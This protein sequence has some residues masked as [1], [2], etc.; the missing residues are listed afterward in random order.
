MFTLI[1]RNYHLSNSP[2]NRVVPQ[3]ERSS[4][5][6]F[7]SFSGPSAMF[8]CGVGLGAFFWM[9]LAAANFLVDATLHRLLPS[10]SA[11]SH[12]PRFDLCCLLV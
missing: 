11:S 8:D 4:V 10:P 7:S 1:L 2:A 3:R 6:A 12:L 9:M 5:V